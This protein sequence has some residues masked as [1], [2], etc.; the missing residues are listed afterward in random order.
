MQ[1][2][3]FNNGCNFKGILLSSTRV[4]KGLITRKLRN[5]SFDLERKNGG[6]EACITAGFFKNS[7]KSR[8][9]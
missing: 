4:T 1:N 7:Q 5:Y 8:C 2:N 9:I 6:A 3:N